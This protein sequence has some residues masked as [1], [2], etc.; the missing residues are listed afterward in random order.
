MTRRIFAAV[1]TAAAAAA[2][3][4]NVDHNLHAMATS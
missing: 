4:D 3:A 1:A 2:A